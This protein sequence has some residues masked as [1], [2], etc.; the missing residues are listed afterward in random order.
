[1]YRHRITTRHEGIALE[2]QSLTDWLVIDSA[3][4]GDVVGHIQLFLGVYEVLT[5]A[6]PLERGFYDTLHSAIDSFAPWERLS[7][8]I[9]LTAAIMQPAKLTLVDAPGQAVA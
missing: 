5:K 1:V 6:A 4:A 3:A 8:V 2:P 9:P 7:E